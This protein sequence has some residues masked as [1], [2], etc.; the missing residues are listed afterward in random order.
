MHVVVNHL[1]LDAPVEE[2]V[3]SLRAEGVEL[4][5]SLPGFRSFY[6]VK[7]ASDRAIVVIVWDSL[8]DAAAGAKQFGSTW[9]AQHIAPH[10]ASEQQRT[11]GEALAHK[12]V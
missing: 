7:E 5:S 4:L 2:F 8:E 3:P 10:L 12:S 11:V 9:F 6:F 1:H